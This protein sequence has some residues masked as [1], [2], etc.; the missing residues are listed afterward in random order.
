MTVRNEESVDAEKRA[1]RQC[2]EA[3]LSPD[4]TPASRALRAPAS[5]ARFRT[6]GR[7][8][9]VVVC[10]CVRERERVCVCEW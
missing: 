10:V 2:K 1:F 8:R 9:S 5:I 3:A 7:V 4:T 6:W